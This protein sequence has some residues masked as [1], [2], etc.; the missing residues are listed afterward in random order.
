[1]PI[2]KK[3]TAGASNMGKPIPA[4]LKTSQ[5]LEKT[6]GRIAGLL[7]PNI[8]P[9]D[10]GLMAVVVRDEHLVRDVRAAIEV[11][12]MNFG[13]IAG[14]PVPEAEH[15]SSIHSGGPQVLDELN[16]LAELEKLGD[17]AI[18]RTFL[19]YGSAGNFKFCSDEGQC[20]LLPIIEDTENGWVT[21]AQSCDDLST[22]HLIGSV[23]AIRTAAQDA[24]AYVMLLIVCPGKRPIPGVRDFCDEYLEIEA[25]EADPGAHLAFSVE[26]MRLSSLHAL[27]Y[28]KVIC[29]ITLSDEGYVR[30]FEPFIAKSMRDRFIWKL[31]AS[32][33]SLA[34]IG[35]LTRLNKSTVK[36]RLDEMRP[37]RRHAISEDQIAQYVEALELAESGEDTADNV[38]VDTENY[39]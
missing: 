3:A 30:K 32:G 33:K 37:I 31:R 29:N 22:E 21:V 27:G 2:N 1:M 7:R 26:A 9:M 35:K 6:G 39:E 4:P 38:N 36:R 11:Q 5:G 13:N 16:A 28:G 10:P 14:I 18:E 34:E 23:C 17:S 15:V 19:A 8:H 12:F 25:C 20:V 24:G